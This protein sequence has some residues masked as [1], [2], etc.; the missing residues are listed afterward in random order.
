VNQ[1]ISLRNLGASG[2]SIQALTNSGTKS[3]KFVSAGVSHTENSV[4]YA[5]LGNS[6]SVYKPWTPKVGVYSITATGYS[7]SNSSGIAGKSL[8]VTITITP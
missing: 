3:V 6:G 5:F 7:A 1:T 2:I 8:T 4:P